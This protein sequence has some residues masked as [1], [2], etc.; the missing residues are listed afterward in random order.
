MGQSIF[1]RYQEL[2][3]I[4]AEMP[5]DSYRGSDIIWAAKKL[6]QNIMITS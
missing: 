1:V 4:K 6:N 3:K 5:E 2:F